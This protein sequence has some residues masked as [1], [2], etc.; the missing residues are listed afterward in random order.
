MDGPNEHG[1]IEVHDADGIR[2]RVPAWVL[3]SFAVLPEENRQA[4]SDAFTAAMAERLRQDRVAAAT[5][6]RW[7]DELAR[8][9]HDPKTPRGAH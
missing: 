1:L 9:L 8:R 7:A 4:R 2:Y 6:Q 5:G 3:R